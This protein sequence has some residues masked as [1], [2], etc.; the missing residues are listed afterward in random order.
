VDP[1]NG[2]SAEGDG[3]VSLVSTTAG[4]DGRRIEDGSPPVEPTTAPVGCDGTS[5]VEMTAAEEDGRTI[6][7]G[8][9]PVDPTL[10]GTEEITSLDMGRGATLEVGKMTGSGTPAV[11]P[12]T[13]DDEG[14]SEEV[15]TGIGRSSAPCEDVG[16]GSDCWFPVPAEIA[17]E[18]TNGTGVTVIAVMIVV[19]NTD[20]TVL[21]TTS[22]DDDGDTAGGLNSDWKN[23]ETSSGLDS[24]SAVLVLEDEVEDVDEAGIVALVTICRFTCRGK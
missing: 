9:P 23:D 1:T 22:K 8:T 21:L 4:D 14:A 17:G 16:S 13:E 18:L 5:S 11:D 19:M 24:K 2:A 10:A 6:C 20:S 7:E 12:T 15:G 3:I